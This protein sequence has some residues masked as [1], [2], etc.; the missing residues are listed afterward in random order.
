MPQLAHIHSTARAGQLQAAQQ[1]RPTA[2]LLLGGHTHLPQH[3][4]QQRQPYSTAV[5]IQVQTGA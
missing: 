3:T 4:P 2:H 5:C 1:L